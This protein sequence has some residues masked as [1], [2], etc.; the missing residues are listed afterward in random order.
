MAEDL[1]VHE[2]LRLLEHA[3]ETMDELPLA[4]F[5]RARYRD[6][7]YHQIA[8]ELGL[9]TSQV[10]RHFAAA[11]LHIMKCTKGFDGL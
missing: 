5:E 3:L 2:V 8:E 10:E 4:V 6:L 11:M 7:N 1:P 9:T